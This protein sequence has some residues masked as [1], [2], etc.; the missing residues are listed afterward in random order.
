MF[1]ER[2]GMVA[3]IFKT[4]AARLNVVFIANI[5]AIQ[6]R[7]PHPATLPDNHHQVFSRKYCN[8]KTDHEAIL[9][10]KS[11]YTSK[12]K[13]RR[14]SFAKGRNFITAKE[15]FLELLNKSSF[16]TSLILKITLFV[17]NYP[18]DNLLNLPLYT[19]YL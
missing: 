13:S 3:A 16:V 1:V 2:G 18:N 7:M 8:H 11:I 4:L 17:S 19:E 12:N 14:R 6:T 15:G 5:V 10:V 9:L